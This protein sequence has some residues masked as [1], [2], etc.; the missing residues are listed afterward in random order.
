[1]ATAGVTIVAIGTAIAGRIMIGVGGTMTEGSA[2]NYGMA[3]MEVGSSRM[4][5]IRVSATPVGAVEI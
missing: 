4:G 5:R 1:M 2:A 3:V